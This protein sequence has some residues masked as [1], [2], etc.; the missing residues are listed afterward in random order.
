MMVRTFI[1]LEISEEIRGR[2]W[3]AQQLLLQSTARLTP[4]RPEAMHI[5]LKFLG[6]IEEREIDPIVQAL[7]SIQ[8]RP[9]QAS[10]EGVSGNPPSRPRVVWG[11]VRDGGECAALARRVDEVLEPLGMEKEGRPYRPHV[12]LARV[13]Q[14][15]PSLLRQVKLLSAMAFGCATV[16][17]LKL[18]KST[19]TP[20]GPLYEDLAEVSF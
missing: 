17:S 15:D 2:M 13:R 6:E 4:V 14:F 11:V 1:A 19:L 10:V 12:T 3:E 16:S 8:F 20:K 7:S 18:K 9:F 5:T